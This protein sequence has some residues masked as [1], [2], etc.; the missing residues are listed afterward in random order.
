MSLWRAGCSETGT[1]GSGGRPGETDRQQCQHRALGRPHGARLARRDVEIHHE[2]ESWAVEARQGGPE[3][4]SQ[5]CGAHS[6]TEARNIAEQL[7]QTNER[8]RLME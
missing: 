2:P 5:Q 6:E 3:G 8:W 7:M 4:E 1:S